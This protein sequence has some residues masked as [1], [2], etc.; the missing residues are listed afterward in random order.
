L[1]KYV[2]EVPV[3][4]HNKK[5]CHKKGT[6]NKDDRCLPG[7]VSPAEAQLRLANLIMELSFIIYRRN[8]IL[9]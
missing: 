6:R 8:C 1:S 5:T 2:A 3:S 4:G 9:R 7:P